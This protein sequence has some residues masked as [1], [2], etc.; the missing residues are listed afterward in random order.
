MREALKTIGLSLLILL[1][2]TACTY[3]PFIR[4]NH[5]TGS[6][7]GLA[8]GGAVGAGSVALFNG[9]KPLM[10]LAGVG[11]AALGY[12]VTT[13]RFDAGGVIKSGGQVYRLGQ[14]VAINIPTDALFEPNTATFLPQTSNLL[15]SVAAVL[16]RYP[17]NNILISGNTSGFGRAR[18]EQKLSQERAKQVAAY[19]W[20]AGI[21]QLKASGMDSRKL[22]YV[23]YGDFFPIA[24]HETNGGIRQNSHLQIT[25][26]PSAVDLG[27]GKR[28]MAMHNIGALNDD[29]TNAP[30]DNPCGGDINQCFKD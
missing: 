28:H 22:N 10:V 17:N 4:N 9:P 3:N 29:T 14:R 13:L 18:F 20:N 19:L 1:F 6:P 21:N 23:G 24:S 16:R 11:G 26:Y 5:T 25:S 2:M 8:I 12:Y 30:D 15:D 27:L 7:T